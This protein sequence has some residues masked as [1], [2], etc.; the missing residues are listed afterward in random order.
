MG[1]LPLLSLGTLE[2]CQ[3]GRSTTVVLKL[4]LERKF[5]LNP[6][7]MT[8]S[9]SGRLNPAGDYEASAGGKAADGRVE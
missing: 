5:K 2:A 4:K 1:Y 3:V 8:R 7:Y 9:A 6:S